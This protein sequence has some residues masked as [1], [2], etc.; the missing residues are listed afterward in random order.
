MLLHYYSLYVLWIVTPICVWIL[1]VIQWQHTWNVFHPP[2]E[3]VIWNLLQWKTKATQW[4]AWLGKDLKWDISSTTTYIFYHADS[5]LQQY[6][7]TESDWKFSRLGSVWYFRFQRAID[8][9]SS[10]CIVLE[11]HGRACEY[12]SMTSLDLHWIVIREDPAGES[13]S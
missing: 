7:F 4:A 9:C 11:Y 13:H 2:H 12:F 6:T 10:D 1:L 5:F 3:T 8:K